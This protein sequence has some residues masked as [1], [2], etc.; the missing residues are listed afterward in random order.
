MID[1]T[2]PC[3]T[4]QRDFYSLR[5]TLKKGLVAE[6]VH[7]NSDKD[8]KRHDFFCRW[9]KYRQAVNIVNRRRDGLS[10]NLC[11]LLSTVVWTPACHATPCLE[12]FA[13]KQLTFPASPSCNWFP[14]RCSWG[15][16]NW[17]PD[18]SVT[19]KCFLLI[20]AFWFFS[21]FRTFTKLLACSHTKILLR[22]VGRLHKR[23]KT[24]Q[25]LWIELINIYKEVNVG[26]DFNA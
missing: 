18:L 5:P 15:T 16:E 21:I 1:S 20:V 24:P 14:L 7:K 9:I 3:R 25:R 17:G 13:H 11:C 6:E 23:I 12:L 19:L 2:V 26:N 10:D 4:D 22:C 8:K